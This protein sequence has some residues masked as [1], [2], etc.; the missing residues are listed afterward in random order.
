MYKYFKIVANTAVGRRRYLKLLI[1]QVLASDIVDRYDLWVNTLDKIDIAYFEAMAEEFPKLNL[2]WQPKG[3][4]NGIYSIADFYPMCRE[5]N[6]IYIKLDDDVVWLEPDFFEKICR[7]RVENP[8]YFLVSP[9]VINNGICNYLLQATGKIEF[10]KTHPCQPYEL[11]FYNGFLAEQ[12]HEWFIGNYLKTGNFKQLYCGKHEISLQRFA[13]NTVAW[14]G[15]EFAKFDGHVVGDDEEFLTLSYPANNGLTH[16][17]DCQTIVSHFSFSAQ[18]EY[19]DQTDILN[20]YEEII[21]NQKE[22][23]VKKI[24]IKGNEILSQVES[25]AIS[26]LQKPIP[27]GYRSGTNQNKRK[28]LKNLA[29]HFIAKMF[30]MPQNH[31]ASIIQTFFMLKKSQQDYIK[32]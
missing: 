13:I 20:L 7:F 28:F 12:L 15:N 4:I 26:I 14:F 22:E 10:T 19:L 27:H 29:L 31:L 2:I 30:G 21:L 32:R 17:F 6:T 16:C 1:P 11:P 3:I 9:L 18:R 8:H 5:E 23:S 24:F 25:E